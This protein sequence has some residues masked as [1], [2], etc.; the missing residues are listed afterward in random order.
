MTLK[1]ISYKQYKTFRG[2]CL[3]KI[4]TGCLLNVKSGGICHFILLE[5]CT[6]FWYNKKKKHGNSYCG[7]FQDVQADY[8]I[9]FLQQSYVVHLKQMNK[10]LFLTEAQYLI[11]YFKP[12]SLHILLRLEPIICINILYL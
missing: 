7:N 10:E 11:L 2:K 12:N 3:Q 4:P 1:L 5:P 6:I 9:S 8:D